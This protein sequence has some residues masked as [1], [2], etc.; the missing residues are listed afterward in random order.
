M[1]VKERNQQP[2]NVF[3]LILEREVSSILNDI[4]LGSGN[5]I[6]KPV[7]PTDYL[8]CIVRTPNQLDWTVSQLVVTVCDLQGMFRVIVSDLMLE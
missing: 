4:Q 8:P 5:S 2:G 3:W 6:L 7:R 1:S